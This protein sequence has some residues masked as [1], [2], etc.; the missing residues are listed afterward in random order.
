MNMDKHNAWIDA[1]VERAKANA[2]FTH[3]CTK[4][5]SHCCYEPA[6]ADRMAVDHMLAALTP[7]QIEEV[8]AKLPE[9]LEKTA[10][11]RNKTERPNAWAWRDLKVACPFLKDNLCVAYERRPFDC[12]IFFAI[13]N[14]EDCKM[15][16]RKHQKFSDYPDHVMDTMMRPFMVEMM[17]ERKALVL[18]HI[19]VLLAERLLNISVPSK[20]RR[21]INPQ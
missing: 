14:P 4:G 20:A 10:E 2:S 17:R 7:E 13:G 8:K 12:R 19:G 15:P 21:E 6:Y 3:C 16:A 5:C 11:L 18:D 9:W 1:C